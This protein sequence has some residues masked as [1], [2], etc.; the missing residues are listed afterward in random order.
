M[1]VHRGEPVSTLLLPF[2]GK[3]LTLKRTLEDWGVSFPATWS[4]TGS[5][6]DSSGAEF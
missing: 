4:P 1:A 6:S 5:D 3:P 2:D